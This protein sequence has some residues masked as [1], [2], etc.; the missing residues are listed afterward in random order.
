[1]NPQKDAESAPAAPPS[2]KSADNAPVRSTP[3]K[4]TDPIPVRSTPL[5]ADDTINN[6]ICD[7]LAKPD[8]QKLPDDPTLDILDRLVDCIV[9]GADVSEIKEEVT[10]LVSHPR[11]KAEIIAA[12][13]RNHEYRRFNQWLRVRAQSEELIFR[14]MRRGELSTAEAL[15]FMR[16]ANAEINQFTATLAKQ[17]DKTSDPTSLLEKVDVGKAAR[18]A[19]S[20]DAYKGTTPHGREIIRRRV[21]A[22]RRQLKERSKVNAKI[23]EVTES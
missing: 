15:A 14:S 4:N 23:I 11:E 22:L 9:T 7:E 6:F 20:A 10:R 17:E 2:R 13:L 1:M 21:F 19:E 3:Q 18:E 12:V 5:T 8:S 16:A